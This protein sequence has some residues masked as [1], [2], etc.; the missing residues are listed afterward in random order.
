[1]KIVTWN[2]NSIRLRI[3]LLERLTDEMAPDVVCLQ[4]TKC[5]DDLFPHEALTRLGWEHV[6]CHGQKGYNGV[7]ILSRR[8][9]REVRTQA[10]CERPDCRHIIAEVD[11]MEVHSLYIPAGGDEPDPAKNPK[12]AN[13]LRFLDELTEWFAATYGPRDPLVLAGDF[14]VAPL[15]TDVWDH[16]KLLKVVTH[17]PMETTRLALLQQTL[18]WVDTTRAFVPADEHVFTWWSYRAADWRGANKGRRL[19]HVWVTPALAPRLTGWEVHVD[20]RDW[21]QPSDHAPVAAVLAD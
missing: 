3:D 20:A 12:F 19:D 21:P 17:T 15:P 7:A 6:A 1:M 5:P 2:V 9:L 14:N 8:P 4:E 11:G 16:K 13:K 18:D 10:W